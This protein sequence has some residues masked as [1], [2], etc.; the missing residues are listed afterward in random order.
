TRQPM[1]LPA[2]GPCPG[3]LEAGRTQESGRLHSQMATQGRNSVR[4]Q[5]S[6]MGAGSSQIDTRLLSISALAIHFALRGTARRSRQSMITGPYFGW[7]SRRCSICGQPRAPAQAA[8][9]RKGVVGRPGSTTPRAPSPRA[10]EAMLRQSRFI[11]LL[12]GVVAG[13]DA[14]AVFRGRWLTLGELVQQPL[15]AG[16]PN[17][18]CPTVNQ[19][20]LTQIGDG[21]GEGFRLDRQARG[22][23][24][25][26][27]EQFDLGAVGPAIATL[28]YQVERQALGGILQGQV[29]QL[30]QALVQAHAHVAQQV[31]AGVGVLLQMAQH[32]LVGKAYEANRL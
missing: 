8:S 10:K 1:L 27:Q 31:Q 23:Q 24:A 12:S 4:N 11:G 20:S 26:G 30:V 17:D 9:S 2:A 28:S 32:Q 21:P 7:R 25:L 3:D 19:P 16:S 29:L 15:D 6:S 18:P 14:G 13:T 5:R 22:N